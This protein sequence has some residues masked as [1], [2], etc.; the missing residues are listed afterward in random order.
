MRK[1][2]YW[3]L[4]DQKIHLKGVNCDWNVKSQGKEY[5]QSSQ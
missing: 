4:Y 5:I 2:I 1:S 3:F